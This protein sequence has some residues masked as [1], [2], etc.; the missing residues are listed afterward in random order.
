MSYITIENINSI[1]AELTNYCNAACPMCA[2]YFL[3]GKAQD[4]IINNAHTSLE[5]FAEKIPLTVI[6]RLE[7]FRSCGNLGDGAMAPESLQI[8]QYVRKHNR[9]VE[10]QLHSNGGLR[11]KEFWQ[12]LAKLNVHV[13]FAIDGL[14]DT[15]HL[16][17]RNVKW[18]RL[19]ANVDAF[20]SAGGKASWD[21]L[22]F[23][24]NE[25]QIEDCKTLSKKLGFLDFQSKNSSRW[26][27]YDSDGNWMDVDSIK[28][29]DYEIEKSSAV[30]IDK[31][32]SGGN[33]ERLNIN[34]DDFKTKKI[35]CGS[36]DRYI[37]LYI[38]ANGDVSPCCWLGD[39]K[40]HESKNIIKDYDAVNLNYTSLDNI[41]QGEFF[42]TLWQG[43]QGKENSYRLHTCYFT[44][45]VN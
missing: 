43:I 44:C 12:E 5:F 4:K 37:E 40:L 7:R 10:L 14:Q 6:K 42:N 39:L 2:R 29:D 19:M 22:V 11:S 34:K 24:H 1:N 21:M 3:D 31:I 36:F 17:R 30:K 35:K 15:N 20:I 26:A 16:Y 32:G 28:V 38:A 25:H 23:K 45:G 41:L 13:T 18:E 8:F 27:D 33:S 9:K